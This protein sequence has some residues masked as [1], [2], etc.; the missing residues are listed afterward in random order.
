MEALLPSAGCQA[1]Y[2]NYADVYVNLFA[3]GNRKPQPPSQRQSSANFPTKDQIVKLLSFVST[4]SLSQLLSP[5]RTMQKQPWPRR[6]QAGVAA[7]P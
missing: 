1:L 2:V 6:K 5:A 7:F 3:Y 4:Q